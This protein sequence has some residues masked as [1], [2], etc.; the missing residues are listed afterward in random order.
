M[1]RRIIAGI[2]QVAGI[3]AVSAGI[4][5]I[6]GVWPG[7]L[8]FGGALIVFGIAEERTAQRAQADDEH[9]RVDTIGQRVLSRFPPAMPARRAE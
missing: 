4:G 7:V 1:K 9:A 6:A 2:L 3:F 8:T 5:G